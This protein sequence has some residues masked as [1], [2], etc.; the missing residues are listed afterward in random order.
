MI[1]VGPWDDGWDRGL[2]ELRVDASMFD[3]VFA[4][5]AM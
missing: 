5:M 2:P 3:F 4:K 1:H